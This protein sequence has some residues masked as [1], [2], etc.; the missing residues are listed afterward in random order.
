MTSPTTQS[1]QVLPS[2]SDSSPGAI[3]SLEALLALYS[4]LSDIV[5]VLQGRLAE[6]RCLSEEY[7]DI[8]TSLKEQGNICIVDAR[9][10]ETSS[11]LT[12]TASANLALEARCQILEAEL[13]K[14]IAEMKLLE[15]DISRLSE[16]RQG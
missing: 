11:Q 12:E 1:I 14:A 7:N 2:S 15:D 16:Y 3:P 10:C 6:E 4:H 9:R 8:L 13:E 5:K